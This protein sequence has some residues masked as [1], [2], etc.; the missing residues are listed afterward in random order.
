MKVCIKT[1]K[2]ENSTIHEIGG[3]DIQFLTHIQL[4]Y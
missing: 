2:C 4:S 3:R 1:Y